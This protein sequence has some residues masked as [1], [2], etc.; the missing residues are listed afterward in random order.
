MDKQ[1]L[2]ILVLLDLKKAFDSVNHDILL[3]KLKSLGFCTIT[4]SWFKSYLTD[5]K[6]RVSY[7]DQLSDSLTLKRGVPQ[8]S[9]LGPLLFSI[10]INDISSAIQNVN[11]H[12]YA[13][14]LQLYKHSPALD[15]INSI[16]DVNVVLPRIELWTRENDLSINPKKCEA[17]IIGS[18]KLRTKVENRYLP[19]LRICGTSIKTSENLRNLG[20]IF[21]KNMN[22]DKH[23]FELRRR[24]YAT[25]KHLY[26][27]KN[28]LSVKAKQLLTES[29]VLSKLDYCDTV[30]SGINIDLATQLQKIMNSCLRYIYNARKREHITPLLFKA[31]W[32]SLKY[33]LQFHGVCMLYKTLKTGTPNYLAS[34]FNHIGDVHDYNT[35]GRDSLVIPYHNLQVTSQ[36]FKVNVIRTWNSLPE[37]IKESPLYPV[38]KIK[39]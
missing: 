15:L 22:W 39:V 35:R 28:F 9:I 1:F 26:L 17:I 12:L 3:H 30:Y 21:D 29:L 32:L 37:Q 4:L 11:Y 16:S 27:F 36:S 8:G 25:L 18:A 31:G 6:Q 13:D 5:H 33:R 10:F 7:Q 20:V 38:F 23:I 2:T 24:C 34:Q 14:D 19:D